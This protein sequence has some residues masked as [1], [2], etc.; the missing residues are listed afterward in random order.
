MTFKVGT[1]VHSNDFGDGIV[2]NIISEVGESHPVVVKFTGSNLTYR[3]KIDG[4]YWLATPDE[5]ADIR[6]RG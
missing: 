4:Q 6:V 1:L 5:D 3:F 2:T